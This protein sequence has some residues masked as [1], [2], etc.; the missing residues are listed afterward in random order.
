MTI[1]VATPS[2]TGSVEQPCAQCGRPVY[3]RLQWGQ[4]CHV[5]SQGGTRTCV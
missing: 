1:R 2:G 5:G 3:F 4:W